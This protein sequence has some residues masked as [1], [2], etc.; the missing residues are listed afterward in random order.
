MRCR[1]LTRASQSIRPEKTQH[2]TYIRTVFVLPK[3]TVVY[4]RDRI[5]QDGRVYEVV[6][7]VTAKGAR[8]AHHVNA[9]CEAVA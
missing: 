8:S 6:D 5:R 9:I 7:V 4:L 2:A 1:K 3:N